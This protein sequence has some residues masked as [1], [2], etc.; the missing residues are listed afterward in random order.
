MDKTFTFFELLS[1]SDEDFFDSVG[2]FS[3]A[4]HFDSP[5]GILEPLESSLENIRCFAEAFD[6]VKTNSIGVVEMILN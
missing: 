5:V 1:M 3:N 2:D 6:V 4:E